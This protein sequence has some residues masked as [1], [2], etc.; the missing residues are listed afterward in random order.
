VAYGRVDPDLV[1]FWQVG[2]QRPARRSTA[3]RCLEPGIHDLDLL[4]RCRNHRGESKKQTR[5][6]EQNIPPVSHFGNP[7]PEKKMI[8]LSVSYGQVTI[9]QISDRNR[10]AFILALKDQAGGLSPPPAL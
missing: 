7:S 4:V 9:L 5:C 2:L 1:P 6:L 8:R 3:F 10:K